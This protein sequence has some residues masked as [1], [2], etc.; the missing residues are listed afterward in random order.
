ML[1][2][3][4]VDAQTNSHTVGIVH[5]WSGRNSEGYPSTTALLAAQLGP[6]LPVS[7]VNFGGYAETGGL[8]RYTRLDNPSLLRSIAYPRGQGEWP[9]SPAEGQRLLHAR[10]LERDGAPPRRNRATSSPQ[11][12]GLLPGESRRLEFF[13][14]A[15]AS[16]EG[17]EGVCRCHPD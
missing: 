13:R 8:T 7:Y 9:D 12:E 17:P 1:V 3:N 10:G 15:F 16:S 4:G 11:S 5:N 2:I 6:N 14:S